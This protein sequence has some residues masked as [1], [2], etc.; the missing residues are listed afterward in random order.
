MVRTKCQ[1][2]FKNT[3]EIRVV[4]WL[5]DGG[6]WSGGTWTVAGGSAYIVT[7]MAVCFLSRK[8]ADKIF[9]RWLGAL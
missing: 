3:S 1:G 4:R 7:T 5:W 9:E 2:T 8:H 6:V